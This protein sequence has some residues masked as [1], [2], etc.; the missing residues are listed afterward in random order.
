MYEQLI[1][2]AAFIDRAGRVV[3]QACPFKTV[4]GEH[5][6]VMEQQAP[7]A[8]IRLDMDPD[9]GDSDAIEWLAQPTRP[10]PAEGFVPG[11]VSKGPGDVEGGGTG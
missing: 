9:T 8:M 11:Q 3:Y 7:I 2:R 5:G 1:L 4:E 6:P 10:T